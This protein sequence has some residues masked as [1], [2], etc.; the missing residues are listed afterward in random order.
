[1]NKHPSGSPH[2]A[3]LPILRYPG[4]NVASPLHPTMG[5]CRCGFSFSFAL[6]NP[7]LQPGTST[8]STLDPHFVRLALCREALPPNRMKFRPAPKPTP[9]MCTGRLCK[10]Q[11]KRQ[12]LLLQ[13]SCSPWSQLFV[14]DKHLAYSY[15]DTT[16]GMVYA[17]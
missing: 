4:F 8:I 17:G 6:I 2:L 3:L 11:K 15:R 5:P 9:I 7:Q 16:H 12:P 13:S 1:M 10:C 14:I